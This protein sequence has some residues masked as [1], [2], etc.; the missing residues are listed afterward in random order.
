M[1]C[2]GAVLRGRRLSV[3]DRTRMLTYAD[4]CVAQ[5]LYGAVGVSAYMIVRTAVLSIDN[6][7]A[8]AARRGLPELKLALALT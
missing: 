8:G 2:A 4:V 1:R 6:G 5:A 7:Q 3:Y